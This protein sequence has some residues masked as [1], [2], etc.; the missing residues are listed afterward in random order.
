MLKGPKG[1]IV[2]VGIRREGVRE[3][4]V[5]DI[6]RDKIPIYSLDAAHMVDDHIGYIKDNGLPK[7]PWMNSDRH[8]SICASACVI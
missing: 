5:F 4:L 6:V 7:P 2:Q 8:C 3:L 1:T